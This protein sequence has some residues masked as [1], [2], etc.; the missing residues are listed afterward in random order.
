MN[1]DREISTDKGGV[2]EFVKNTVSRLSR[3]TN[4]SC[5]QRALISHEDAAGIAITIGTRSDAL[6]A[7]FQEFSKKLL[8][9]YE[10]LLA[11]TDYEP[12]RLNAAFFEIDHVRQTFEQSLRLVP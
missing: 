7:L 2:P 1:R 5:K 4:D 9:F 6:M 3:P 11:G 8:A 10:P 12:G